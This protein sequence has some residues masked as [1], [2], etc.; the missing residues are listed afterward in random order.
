MNDYLKG[1]IDAC[2]DL[3][4]DST[5]FIANIKKATGMTDRGIKGHNYIQ[6]IISTFDA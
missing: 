4:E 3:A 1:V 2:A 6:G 5:Q